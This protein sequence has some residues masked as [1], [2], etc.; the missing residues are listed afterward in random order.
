MQSWVIDKAKTISLK[1]EEQDDVNL[2]THARVKIARASL[3]QSDI[4]IYQEKLGKLPI[5]PSRSALGVISESKL[6]S[7][8]KGQRV[9]LSP[10]QKS[11]EKPFDIVGKD[12]NGY[13]SDFCVV[14]NENIYI[15]PESIKDEDFTFIEEI[16]MAIKTTSLIGLKQTH[17]IALFGA[18]TFNVILGQLALYYQAIPIIVD[19]KVDALSLAEQFGIYYT[20]NST[21]EDVMSKIVEITSGNLVEHIV[22]DTDYYSDIN[23]DI[24]DMANIHGRIAFVGYDTTL[25]KLKINAHYII[26]K[27]LSIFGINDGYG[28][29]EPAINMLATE[30]VQVSGLLENM[31]DF[32]EVET[33]FATLSAKKHP[34]KNIVRC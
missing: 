8:S 4:A 14:P 34:L 5:I 30:V 9:Y 17:Y 10:Y 22:V 16:A 1:Q 12:T 11:A 23:L 3:C 6:K 28:E 2:R 18:T 29:I 13:L 24:L 19:S 20:I 27:G 7:L 33:A 32:S 31:Y 26:S 25:D 21:K 15:V